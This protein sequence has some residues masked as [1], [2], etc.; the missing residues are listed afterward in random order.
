[1]TTGDA[2]AETG[3][4]YEH[5]FDPARQPDLFDGVRSRRILAFLIDVAF[6]LVWMAVASAVIAVLGL[7]TLSLGWLLFALVW[8]FVPILYI[9]FTLG[10][11]RSATPGMRMAGLQMR[12]WYGAPMYPLLAIVHGVLFWFFIV[13]LTPFVLVVGLLNPRKRLLHDYISGTV[14]IR[15][16]AV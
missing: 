5:A 1:M 11:S 13:A 6:I 10:G 7:L 4:S 16:P 9:A 15:T 12:T 14:L 2:L 8:P 3:P